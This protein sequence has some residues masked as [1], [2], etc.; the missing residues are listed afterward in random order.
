MSNVIDFPT[1]VGDN[2]RIILSE[3]LAE[4]LQYGAGYAHEALLTEIEEQI[5][6]HTIC[7]EEAVDLYNMVL[8][9]NSEEAL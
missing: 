2:R 1:R 5:K 6:Y 3:V 9:N 7:L 4:Y 8:G